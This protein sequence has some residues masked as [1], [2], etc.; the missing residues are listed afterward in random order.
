MIS[1]KLLAFSIVS[2]TTPYCLIL[3]ITICS[4]LNY[5]CSRNSQL[6]QQ[7]WNKMDLRACACHKA[8]LLWFFPYSGGTGQRGEFLVLFLVYYYQR[9]MNI[10][11]REMEN[12]DYFLS[13]EL[14]SVWAVLSHTIG[15][16]WCDHAAGID[17]CFCEKRDCYNSLMLWVTSIPQR[18]GGSGH[19]RI[20]GHYPAWSM[21]NKHLWRGIM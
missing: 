6:H 13:S 17:Q 5:K 20:F 12:C 19:L 15:S 1:Y 9:I 3:S 16:K 2:M 4:V 21:E 18:R 11:L 10:S 14:G 7:H 8:S